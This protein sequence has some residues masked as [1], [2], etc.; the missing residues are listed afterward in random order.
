MKKIYKS[1][2]VNI[3]LEDFCYKKKK[4]KN[5][6]KVFL[7][8]AVMAIITNMD[9]QILLTQE[10]R[11]GVKSVVYGFPGG[12]MSQK[13][14]PL[15]AIKREVKEETGLNCKKWKRILTYVKDSTY[16][17][18]RDYLFYAKYPYKN[19][20]NKVFKCNE[21]ENLSWVSIDKFRNILINANNSAGFLASGY[22]FLEKIYFKSP[23]LKR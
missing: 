16:F 21:I 12:H 6:H 14:T 20:K 10:Y 5:F 11:R 15:Q 2:F 9:N 1:K 22:Y 18:G 7:N 8:N 19:F 17:C 13:E 23:I 4:F 3:F